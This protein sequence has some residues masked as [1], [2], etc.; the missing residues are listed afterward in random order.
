MGV[1]SP[2]SNASSRW[3]ALSALVGLIKPRRSAASSS[4][5]PAVSR[6]HTRISGLMLFAR[7][8]VRASPPSCGLKEGTPKSGGRGREYYLLSPTS[9][10]FGMNCALEQ[11]CNV[12]DHA[13]GDVVGGRD[14][15]QAQRRHD[16][17]AE[18]YYEPDVV[19][20]RR[21][22]ASPRAELALRPRSRGDPARARVS[23]RD[24]TPRSPRAAATACG[25]RFI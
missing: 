10:S 3:A 5:R 1:R 24:A 21:S 17:A 2:L 7:I 15:R 14:A 6:A 20:I 18:H 22:G 12:A 8:T 19:C 13:N 9:D 25:F 4:S 23:R 16:R 11:P